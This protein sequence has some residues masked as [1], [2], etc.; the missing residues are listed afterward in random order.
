MEK[1]N[2]I[3]QEWKKLPNSVKFWNGLILL[4][5][6]CIG[7]YSITAL[8]ILLIIG[9]IIAFI[10]LLDNYKNIEDHIWMWFTPFMWVLFLGALVILAGEFI[11]VKVIKPFNNWLN[12]K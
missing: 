7:I 6:N 5:L 11:T 4:I 10:M 8:G 1:L 9:S 2:Y 12:K 3:Q